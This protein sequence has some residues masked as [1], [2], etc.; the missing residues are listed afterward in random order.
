MRLN[1]RPLL[2]LLLATTV[3]AQATPAP[4]ER[5]DL[6]RRLD[7][8]AHAFLADAP[9]Q[10]TIRLV[11]VGDDTFGAEFDAALRLSFVLEDGRG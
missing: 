6:V 4:T 8:L 11:Y 10:G 1:S 2:P 9:G 3:R 5:A 7:S